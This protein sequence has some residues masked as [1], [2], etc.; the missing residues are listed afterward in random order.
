MPVLFN[1]KPHSFHFETVP[2]QVQ[3]IYPVEEIGQCYT[4]QI[5]DFLLGS[6][7]LREKYFFMCRWFG[8]AGRFSGRKA[9]LAKWLSVRLQTKWSWI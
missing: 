4:I 8:Y 9:S 2:I 3:K 1:P 6:D 5:A 7:F